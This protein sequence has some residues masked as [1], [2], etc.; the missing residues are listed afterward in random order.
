VGRDEEKASGPWGG[1]PLRQSYG[2]RKE[3]LEGNC[4]LGGR[5][6]LRMET[7]GMILAGSLEKS[8]ISDSLFQP[9]P[10]LLDLLIN[11]R[12]KLVEPNLPFRKRPLKRLE[13]G[14]RQQLGE[15]GQLV[16]PP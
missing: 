14:T 3:F 6:K 4:G 11:L 15:P 12:L 2:F 13:L 10:H 16:A 1:P 8:G 7:R 9:P 5:W